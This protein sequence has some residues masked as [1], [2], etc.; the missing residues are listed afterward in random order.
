[1]GKQPESLSGPTGEVEV[2]VFP[3]T[4]VTLFPETTK[5]LNIFEPRYIQMI[6]DA[7]KYDRLV[8]LVFTEPTSERVQAVGVKGRLRAIAG[9]GRVNLIERRDDKTMLI[10]LEA[11]GK[12]RLEHVIEDEAPYLKA[13]A[14]WIPEKRELGNENIFILHRLMKALSRW[15]NVHVQDTDAREQ[16]L[17]KLTT[18]E[19][20]INAIC[21]LMVLDSDLQQTLLEVDSVDERCAILAMAI[22]SDGPSQ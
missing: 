18:A 15:L 3:L 22:E 10:L 17:A 7:L 19:Q 13:K 20:R 6:E 14:R 9:V 8:A 11:V 21:S 12:A 5:P 16:F 4:R 2:A 1:M